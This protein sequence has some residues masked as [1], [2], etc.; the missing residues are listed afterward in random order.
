MSFCFIVIALCCAG[1]LF[2]AGQQRVQS[3]VKID[4]TRPEYFV[5]LDSN[6]GS[7]CAGFKMQ[8]GEYYGVLPTPTRAGYTF[9]GWN[10]KNIIDICTRSQAASINAI[11]DEEANEITF[12]NASSVSGNG[13]CRVDIQLYSNS[14]FDT[15]LSRGSS[16]VCSGTFTKSGTTHN[17]VKLKA[18]G[19]NADCAFLF[20]L[21]NFP[22]GEYTVYLNIKSKTASTTYEGRFEKIVIE[23]VQIERSG[24]FTG[25]EKPMLITNSTRNTTVGNHTLTAQW[26]P[27]NYTVT[28]YE[29]KNILN[30][31][32]LASASDLSYWYKSS[33][34]SIVTEDGILCAKI[35]GVLVD[36][37]NVGQTLTGKLVYNAEYII[38]VKTKLVNYVP[39]STHPYIAVY[40]GGNYNNNG[41]ETWFCPLG[42]VTLDSTNNLGWI[43][44]FYHY[45]SAKT[46]PEV[47]SSNEIEASIDLYVRDCTGDVYFRDYSV[48]LATNT[49]NTVA[50]GSSCGSVS[51]LTQSGKTFLG[52]YTQPVGGV[53]IYDSDGSVVKGVSG[54]TDAEGNWIKAEDTKL[55][56]QWDY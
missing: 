7:A 24:S 41:A 19:N 15:E 29:N 38:A 22:D 5:T 40:S 56:A 18:N 47:T 14:S 1:I 49:I 32:K 45:V 30:G 55:Y 28:L 27:N 16:G 26:T 52:Y 44:T 17:A 34:A 23:N 42:I 12:D 54:Y 13:Y 36:N 20:D 11:Y 3:E 31:G 25:Y 51:K 39:G 6:G 50:F 4:Y 43:N 9:K 8:L 2:C 33:R 21:S 37:K 10:G 48:A 35:R 53:K 46:A